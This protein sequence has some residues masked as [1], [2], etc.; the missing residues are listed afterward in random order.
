M[1]RQRTMRAARRTRQ[2]GKPFAGENAGL[3]TD[4]AGSRPLIPEKGFPAP[5]R[6]A[7]CLP[8]PITKGT[9]TTEPAS[10]T[11]VQVTRSRLRQAD[12][13]FIIRAIAGHRLLARSPLDTT[14]RM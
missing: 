9:K 10:I 1:L 5:V 11:R 12:G 8:L 7:A 3:V 4:Q 2:T 13:R 14:K 6:R